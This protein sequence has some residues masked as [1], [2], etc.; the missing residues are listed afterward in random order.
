MAVT[1]VTLLPDMVEDVQRSAQLTAADPQLRH[2]HTVSKR[3]F[4]LVRDTWRTLPLPAST[5][6][7]QVAEVCGV[8][9]LPLALSAACHLRS[10]ISH[11]AQSSC[12]YTH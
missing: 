6:L 5:P 1:A 10:A 7:L 11:L 12:L 9:R 2:P 4:E 3:L 8:L